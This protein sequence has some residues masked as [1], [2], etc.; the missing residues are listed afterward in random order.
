[1]AGGCVNIIK[2]RLYD[3][4]RP[5]MNPEMFLCLN[6]GRTGHIEIHFPETLTGS[7]VLFLTEV[8]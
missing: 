1:M 7:G 5:K 4:I 2:H 3:H 8:I 6:M